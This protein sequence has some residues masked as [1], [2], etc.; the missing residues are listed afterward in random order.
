MKDN[1]TIW[2][3]I[4]SYTDSRGNDK[5]NL[6]LSQRRADAV[7]QYLIDNGVDKNRLMAVGYG[8]TRLLNKCVNG[9]NCTE[10]QHQ[11]NRR[12]EFKIVKQ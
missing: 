9:V 11:L 4:G 12:T 10:E 3:E 7:V 2:L 8:E 6:K 5:Y 1:P